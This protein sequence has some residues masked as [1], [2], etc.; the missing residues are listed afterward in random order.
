MSELAAATRKA[1]DD[2]RVE[3]R[4]FELYYKALAN[5][6]VVI[7]EYSSGEKAP[8]P[9]TR[10]TIR[11]LRP[12]G[13]AV[14]EFYRLAL[15]H[16]ALHEQLGTWAFAISKVTDARVRNALEASSE[17]ASD[18]EVFL[19]TFSDVALAQLC[20]EILED[21]RIDAALPLA[22]PGLVNTLDRAVVRELS[23]R[24]DW[25]LLPPRAA[26][27]EVALR[28]SLGHGRLNSVP[29][30]V[31]GPAR[32][33]ADI[34][35]S[36][37][38]L[39]SQV[40]DIALATVQL[41]CVLN[42]LPNLGVVKGTSVP[43][44]VSG[45]QPTPSSIWPTYWPEDGRVRIEGDDV[46]LLSLPKVS[47]RGSLEALFLEAP[48][49]S[50]PDHQ[51]LYRTRTVSE[52]EENVAKPKKSA[53]TGPPE[54]LPHDHQDVSRHLH[55][56]EEGEL[57]SFGSNTF[58][59]PEW[60][61]YLGRYRPNWC[62]VVQR[63]AN[64]SGSPER[65]DLQYRY[66]TELRR[67][68]RILD[69]Q[70]PQA[71]FVERRT[72][73]GI[74]ID[75]DAAVDA[76]IDYRTSSAIS[77]SVYV[78]LKRKKRDI[79]VL[80]LIDVSA[81]TAERV[82]E[83]EPIEMVLSSRHSAHRK[84]RPPRILDIE[85]ISSLLCTSALSEIGDAFSIWSFS[86]TGREQVVLSEIKGFN[87]P[88]S[89]IVVARAAAMKPMHAT[90]LGAAVRHCGMVLKKVQSET[91][92]LLVLTDGRP[93]DI[94]YGTSYGEGESQSYALADSDQALSEIVNAGIEPY[95]LTVDR[96]GE[97]YVSELKSAKVE[98]LVDVKSLPEKLLRLYT[99]LFTK[100]SGQVTRRQLFS[101][102]GISNTQ[103]SGGL[104][105]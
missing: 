98:V 43:F 27:A 95:I 29:K 67:I 83:A 56:H 4:P 24:P 35:G 54:P 39:Q 3:I 48:N 94:D 65:S 15:A 89:G 50:G 18:L 102:A 105:G 60:D 34:F 77:D 33:I 44:V 64:A 86:G 49:A 79:A 26:A 58:L 41:Y 14:R 75:Y 62:R 85:V 46:L 99:S 38:F 40:E 5:R 11:L 51:A 16:R 78:D 69:L 8:F 68:R 53:V 59:Y 93:F 12:A 28:I 72:A 31:E 25:Y 90:R 104:A 97:Q 36:I 32:N 19:K 92:V 74:D 96:S 10:T 91:K 88:M 103:T 63:R 73:S 70:Q 45:N 55:H 42:Q 57:R 82:E 6:D 66:A 84:F 71:F 37:N 52:N 76:I 13:S 9:D 81:S 22:F 100:S 61:K 21:A 101:G 7:E 17:G 2:F 30:Q 80:L 20:F 87:E 47:Y 1:E 23:H